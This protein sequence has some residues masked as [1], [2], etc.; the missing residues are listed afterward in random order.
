MR[1]AASSDGYQ[2]ESV[3][4]SQPSRSRPERKT[5]LDIASERE[6]L[7]PS[8]STSSPSVTTTTLNPDG[9]FT[10]PPSSSESAAD[11]MDIALYSISL[12]LLHLTLTLLIENQ[13]SASPSTLSS[14]PSKIYTI[15][16]TSPQP[17]VL[18]LLVA[19]LHPRASA[20]ATQLFFA[21]MS[22]GC[23]SW[24]VHTTNQD[25]YLAVMEKAPSLGTLWVWSVV[26]LRSE[27]GVL[28]VLLV[29]VWGW[30]KGYGFW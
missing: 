10:D 16:I 2:A 27:L 20:A 13:Y 7:S 3:P 12:I 15:T 8:S 19:G 21:A 24:L 6:L 18:L 26:E 9:T 14:L 23:G 17:Y 22:V 4:L 28:T 1:K 25:P 11:Y 30:L 29:G 5:L